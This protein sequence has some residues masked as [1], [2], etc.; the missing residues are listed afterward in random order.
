MSG[1][2]DL[3]DL[4]VVVRRETDRAYGIADPNKAGIIW[5]P[6]SQCQI[7]EIAVPSGKATLTCREWLAKERGLI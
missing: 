3:V 1:R 7:D 4:V 2:Y 5:M 6:K